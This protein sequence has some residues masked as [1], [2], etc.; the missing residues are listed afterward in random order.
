MK[1][2]WKIVWAFTLILVLL[3]IVFPVY[4]ML[5]FSISDRDSFIT[6][7]EYSPPFWPFHPILR[8]TEQ[9]SAMQGW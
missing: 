1:K 5:Q 9:C 2:V 7:G 8:C 6:G 3:S 4:M